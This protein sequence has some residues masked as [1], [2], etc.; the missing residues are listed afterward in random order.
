MLCPIC[1]QTTIIEQA[2]D[3]FYKIMKCLSCGWWQFLKNLNKKPVED[4]GYINN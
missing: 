4:A 3:S 1:S 2:D